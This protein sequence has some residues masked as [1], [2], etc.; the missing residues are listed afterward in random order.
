MEKTSGPWRILLVE[1]EMLV[2][3]LLE[4]MLSE[5]GHTIIGPMARID[6]AV[7]AART[8]TVDLAILDVNVAGE[9][10]YPV[11]EALAAREIPFA[12]A[13]G[14]GAHGLREPWQDRPTLQKP[15]HRADLFRMVAE[16]ASS[17]SC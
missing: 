8:E 5:A 9:E 16:L 13:T 6:Q 7:E 2:A 14:Y 3:M 11:A 17:Y 12:F 1:D 15:F 10:V 4:D